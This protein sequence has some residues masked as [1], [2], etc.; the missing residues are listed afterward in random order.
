M[1]VL[2]GQYID[3]SYR[4]QQS[5]KNFAAFPIFD[6]F[7]RKWEESHKYCLKTIEMGRMIYKNNT[8]IG[9]HFP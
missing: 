9:K 8:K 7:S 3:S 6:I 5:Y 2:F 1:M 4:G